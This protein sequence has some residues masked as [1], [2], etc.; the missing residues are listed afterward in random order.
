MS[1][2]FPER[3]NVF[4]DDN[5]VAPLLAKEYEEADNITKTFQYDPESHMGKGDAEEGSAFTPPTTL[6]TNSQE[7]QDGS[8]FKKYDEEQPRSCCQLLKSTFMII[9]AVGNATAWV[10][11]FFYSPFD[12]SDWNA[13]IVYIA[14]FICLMTTLLMIINERRILS[15]PTS[16]LWLCEFLNLFCI[17]HSSHRFAFRLERDG[18]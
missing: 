8:A 11:S 18:D 17:I 13:V 4:I 10:M 9:L 3:A 15:Y 6:D 2:Y 1:A 12:L 7:D 14:G 5:I 16:K